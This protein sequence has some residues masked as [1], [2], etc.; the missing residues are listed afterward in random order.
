MILSCGRCRQR[1]VSAFAETVDWADGEDPQYWSLLPLIDAEATGLIGRGNATTEAE[2]LMLGPERR[3]LRHDNSKG[4]P[5]RSYWLT[6]M[7][8]GPHD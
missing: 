4:L 3:C 5:P 1:F 7:R 8:I 6:G 2:L